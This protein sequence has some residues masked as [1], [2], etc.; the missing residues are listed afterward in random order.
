MTGVRVSKDHS[1]I[2]IMVA[3]ITE[4]Y[5]VADIT[6]FRM[7][8]YSVRPS[9]L[10]SSAHN[11]QTIPCDMLYN[12]RAITDQFLESNI[13]AEGFGRQIFAKDLKIWNL[14]LKTASGSVDR[15]L[16]VKTF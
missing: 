7:G 4:C 10:G 11:I 6:G 3:D 14:H 1:H 5:T 9:V 16:A 8:I 12:I 2:L 15:W 13:S